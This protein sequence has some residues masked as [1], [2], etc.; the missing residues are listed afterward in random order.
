MFRG[1]SGQAARASQLSLVVN[2][3]EGSEYSLLDGDDHHET[4][5][6]V[7]SPVPAQDRDLNNESFFEYGSRVGV[8]RLMDMF[9]RHGVKSTF[10]S[11]AFLRT[12][13][14]LTQTARPRS[15][16]GRFRVCRYSSRV[17]GA[18]RLRTSPFTLISMHFSR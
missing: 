4:N 7:P 15:R 6:E 10:F 9:Q 12:N 2:Y 16:L 18:A 17:A 14:P 3:E 8:W 11:H 5:G 1:L 13:S